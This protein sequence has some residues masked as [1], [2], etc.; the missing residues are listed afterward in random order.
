MFTVEFL[1][2]LLSLPVL[3]WGWLFTY[4]V[5][6]H[7]RLKWLA[8]VQLANA[9]IFETIWALGFLGI[10]V[11][12]MSFAHFYVF[13][14]AAVCVLGLLAEGIWLFLKWEDGP[15]EL[16]FSALGASVFQLIACFGVFLI[17]ETW[18]SC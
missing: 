9:V 4:A 13:A 2:F 10:I 5:W 18:A 11:F 14:V 8:A 17:M 16:Y 1:F 12:G 15:K 3:I 6:R 7:D